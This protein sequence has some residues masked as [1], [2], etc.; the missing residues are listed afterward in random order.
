MH[1]AGK[2]RS[3]SNQAVVRTILLV[4]TIV[5]NCQLATAIPDPARTVDPADKTAAHGNDAQPFGSLSP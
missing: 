2:G 3:R 4:P 1:R 5:A